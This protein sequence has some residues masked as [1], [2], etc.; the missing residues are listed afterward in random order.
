MTHARVV[1]DKITSGVR[2]KPLGF[3]SRNG[4]I[5]VWYGTYN[6]VLR[7]HVIWFRQCTPMYKRYPPMHIWENLGIKMYKVYQKYM[8]F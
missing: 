4:H 7:F 2:W 3:R 8:R 1:L 6:R 5:F